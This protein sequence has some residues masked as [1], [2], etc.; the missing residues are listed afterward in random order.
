LD[1]LRGFGAYGVL[2]PDVSGL[3]SIDFDLFVL[4]SLLDRSHLPVNEKLKLP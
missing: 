3:V 4:L 2:L 1:C